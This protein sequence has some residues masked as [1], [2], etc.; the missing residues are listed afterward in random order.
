MTS[1]AS[2]NTPNERDVANFLHLHLDTV[3]LINNYP[4]QEGHWI[5]E[6]EGKYRP[7]LIWRKLRQIGGDKYLV[8]PLTSLGLDKHNRSIE[9]RYRIGRLPNLDRV[10]YVKAETHSLPSNLLD[11]KLP[12]V[13]STLDPVTFGSVMKIMERTLLQSPSLRQTLPTPSTTR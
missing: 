6:V 12:C 13:L 5:C 3:R 1:Q 2:D 11:T 4:N 7:M 9:G 10:S 8:F